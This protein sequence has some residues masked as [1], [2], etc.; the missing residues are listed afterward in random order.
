MGHGFAVI[1]PGLE[2]VVAAELAGF[3]IE[4]DVVPGGVRFSADPTRVAMLTRTM[5]TPSQLLYELGSGTARSSEALGVLIRS[6]P[7]KEFLQP[8]AELKVEI[9]SRGSALRF[10]DTVTRAVT[11]MIRDARKG[12]FVPDRGQRP[13]HVQMLQVRIVDDQVTVSLDAGGDLLHKR[14]WR[15]EAGRA[16]IRENLAACLLALAEWDG[17]DALYDPFCGAGTIV[18]EGALLAA[19]K[20]PFQG[21]A[22]FACD[23]WGKAKPKARAGG[24]PPSSTPASVPMVFGSDHQAQAVTTS[25]ANA[26]RA[27]VSVPFRVMDVAEAQ[28]PAVV[29]TIVTNPPYG[30]RL[31]LNVDEVY[32]TFGRVLRERFGSWRVVFLAPD[33]RMALKVDERVERVV[34]F[35]NG[36]LSVGAWTYL[37]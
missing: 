10:R 32:A 11:A 13:R 20:P 6:L 30:E 4:G 7:W 2:E 23:E 16:P 26:R 37:A 36:G 34:Q 25:V 1:H 9:T 29:G 22:G 24:R 3:G 19:G 14:G 5:R 18:I 8:Q 27:G 35:K 12:A 15:V 33:R 21:R 28:P 17:T 31:G